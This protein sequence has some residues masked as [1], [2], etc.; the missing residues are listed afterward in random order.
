MGFIADYFHL[1][2]KPIGLDISPS[3]IKAIELKKRGEKFVVSA[4]GNS[5]LPPNIFSE[6]E[7]V[8]KEVL[9]DQ[10]KKALS[11]AQPKEIETK[12]AV[13]SLP[14]GASFNKLIVFPK[15]KKRELEEAVKWEANQSIPLPPS[16]IY[17]DWE[18]IS[19][20]KEKSHLKVFFQAAP[21]SLVDNYLE[22]LHLAGIVPVAFEIE[23]VALA[24]VFLPILKK[25]EGTIIF[26]IGAKTSRIDVFD[27]GTIQLTGSVLVG[28]EEI[29]LA[30]ARELNL[31]I[32]E[33]EK[34]KKHSPR[35][36]KH[37]SLRFQQAVETALEHIAHE[38]KQSIKF[39]QEHSGRKIEKA[40]LCG[41]SSVLLGIKK[42]LA[43]DLGIKVELGNPLGSLHPASSHI[44]PPG[45]SL[46]YTTAIG[47]ALRG[48]K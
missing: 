21:K 1:Q 7:I 39:Y 46:L 16:E 45:Q 48:E 38:A 34:I 6:N 37:F 14:E 47:L 4:Y 17:L 27:Q 43:K 3:S 12:Q 25:D 40:I 20:E 32:E 23:T 15:M 35:K 31:S 42:N 30:L 44:L 26:D 8:G 28:G 36:D 2:R 9:V 41:G 13:V 5:P 11:E 24:R 10:I 29:T 19:E 33:A 18:I 22:V